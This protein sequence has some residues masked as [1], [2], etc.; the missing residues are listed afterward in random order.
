MRAFENM[1]SGGLIV[2]TV[3][4][5]L[6]RKY[7]AQWRN[8]TGCTAMVLIVAVA[9]VTFVLTN[10]AAADISACEA[11]SFAKAMEDKE[12]H[13]LQEP[14]VNFTTADK[15]MVE[16]VAEQQPI[17]GIDEVDERL[18]SMGKL[19][20]LGSMLMLF[21][22][23]NEERYPDNLEELGQY[24]RDG[25]L[26]WALEN[27][28][29]LG[30]GKTIT[31]SPHAPIAYDKTLLQHGEG[32]NVLFND[33][34]IEAMSY[35]KLQ[36]LLRTKTGFLADVRKQANEILSA[37]H[38]HGLSKEMMIFAAYNED[39]YPANINVLFETGKIN[40]EEFSWLSENVEYL[41]NQKKYDEETGLVLAYDK[42]FLEQYGEGTNVLFDNHQ[43]EFVNSTR[44]EEMGIVSRKDAEVQRR[45]EDQ[46]IEVQARFLTIPLDADEI[47]S[48]LKK[49]DAITSTVDFQFNAGCVFDDKQLGELLKLVRANPD[50]NYLSTP[51]VVA[52]N[53]EDVTMR[54]QEKMEYMV[55]EEEKELL[56]GTVFKV[57]P[58]ITNSGK[59]MVESEFEKR[60][61]LGY[62]EGLP[63]TEVT[64]I[65]SVLGVPDGGTVFAARYDILG[66]DEKPQKIMLF[67]IS[68][69]RVGDD[70]TAG[71]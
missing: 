40:Q 27:V 24:D 35:E 62:E 51:A 43:V 25:I 26:E 61:L 58:V 59:I 37:A 14:V 69:R 5:R 17:N 36:E 38:L 48:F 46:K 22:N 50:A 3:V 12:L 30:K 60:N 57:K 19:K 52:I 18:E 9:V 68:A 70:E 4:L 15:T 29:Y 28:M 2:L 41:G 33:S 11:S 49:E 56:L 64:K 42:T 54:Q 21:I 16:Q 55:E 6:M 32:T 7:S 10:A 53:G 31:I 1:L 47:A 8:L 65:K 67:L 34:H 44:F 63:Q 71:E 20:K 23:D 66:P 39:R 13:T 45:E